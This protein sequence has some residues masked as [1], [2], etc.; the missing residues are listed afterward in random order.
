[1]CAYWTMYASIDP[2]Y[3][4]NSGLGNFLNGEKSGYLCPFLINYD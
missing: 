1:M 4:E 2:N 3:S